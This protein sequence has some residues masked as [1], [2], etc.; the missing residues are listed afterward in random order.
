MPAIN[1]VWCKK[2]WTH[3]YKEEA[4]KLS[5]SVGVSRAAK[6]LGVFPQ[7]TSGG[8][9]RGLISQWPGLP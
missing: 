1:M 9:D 5:E 2:L 7:R 8:G 4:V 6:D 3:Q